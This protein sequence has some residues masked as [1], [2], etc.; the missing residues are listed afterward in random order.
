[1]RCTRRQLILATGALLLGSRVGWAA[2]AA[3][4]V[5]GPAFGA[6]WRATL[7]PVANAAAVTGLLQ[8]IVAE[9]DRE[10]SPF[11]PD[12]AITRFNNRAATGWT[13]LPGASCSVIG[14]SLRIARLT[15]GAFDPTVGALVGRYGFGPITRPAPG[16][17]TGIAVRA[18]AAR[19]DHPAMS[20]DLCGI[21]KGHALDRMAGGLAAL[22]L[23]DFLVEVGGEVFAQGTHPLGRAWQVGIENPDAGP[24]SIRRVVRLDGE[25]L[26]TSG[27]RI[28]SYLLAGQR[29]SH[30][31]DPRARRPARNHLAS[32]SVLAPA[33]VTADGLATALFAMG[34]QAGPAFAAQ[35]R[36]PALFVQRDG[37][38][39]RDIMTGGFGERVLA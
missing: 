22:G 37:A 35:A 12:S 1:M 31:I 11:R 13:A 23:Q 4:I 27:D 6:S 2:G 20:L 36:I 17:H 26:A 29:I 32:V 3:R 14:E 33:A 10:M 24:T 8:S 25:A 28:N 34:E 9:V 16:D 21:A 39:F 30:I 19:K 38:E 18:G 7:P 5:A 15:G